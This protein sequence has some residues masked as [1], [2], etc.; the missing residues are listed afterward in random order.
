MRLEYPI[1]SRMTGHETSLKL[2]EVLQMLVYMSEKTK[3]SLNFQSKVMVP[4]WKDIPVG[5][6]S[7]FSFNPYFWTD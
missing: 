3:Q 5:L 6:I 7:H 4:E 2:P 1:P